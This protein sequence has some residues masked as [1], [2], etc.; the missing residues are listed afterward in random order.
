MLT[1]LVLRSS[2]TLRRFGVAKENREDGNIL[3]LGIGIACV[4]LALLLGLVQINSV[5]AQQR[6]L[7]NIADTVAL[8]YSDTQEANEYFNAIEKANDYSGVPRETAEEVAGAKAVLLAANS[9]FEDVGVEFL[10]STDG[11]I[12]HLSHVHSRAFLGGISEKLTLKVRVEA[13]ATA[14]NFD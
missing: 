8:V 7:A 6:A 13:T 1:N 11:T 10:P 12:V 9:G 14:R 4:A 2:A 5:Y 3:L